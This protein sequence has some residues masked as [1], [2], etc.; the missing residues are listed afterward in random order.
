MRA[1]EEMICSDGTG[2]SP[3]LPRKASSLVVGRHDVID[4]AAIMGACKSVAL[5]GHI[6]NLHTE[7]RQSCKEISSLQS[8]ESSNLAAEMHEGP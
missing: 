7:K 2:T 3:N 6:S 5:F 1:S 8:R 4:V